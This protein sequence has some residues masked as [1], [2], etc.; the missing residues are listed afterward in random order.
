[1]AVTSGAWLASFLPDEPPLAAE[2]TSALA[3]AGLDVTPVVA[4]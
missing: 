1:M 3:A 4:G 2:V